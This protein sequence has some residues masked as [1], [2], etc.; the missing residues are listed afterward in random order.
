MEGR[1]GDMEERRVQQENNPGQ[2]MGR[3]W[4]S[5]HSPSVCV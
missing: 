2:S 1:H 5:G 3:G 4:V